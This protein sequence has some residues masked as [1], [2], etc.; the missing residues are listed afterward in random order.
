MPKIDRTDRFHKTADQ[1][2]TYIETKFQSALKSN[3]ITKDDYTLIRAFIEAKK[4]KNTEYMTLY[5]ILNFIVLWR[6]FMKVPY[7]KA[8]LNDFLSAKVDMENSTNKTGQPLYSKTYQKVMVVTVKGFFRWGLKESKIK[9]LNKWSKISE[10][11]IRDEIKPVKCKLKSKKADDIMKADEISRLIDAADNSRDRCMMSLQYECALRAVDLGRLRWSDITQISERESSIVVNSKTDYERH[12]STVL[13]NGYLNT[14]KRDATNASDKN[15]F[16]FLTYGT[17]QQITLDV[18]RDVVKNAAKRAGITDR[19]ATPHTLRHSR[20]TYWLQHDV[21]I[22][23]ICLMAWG[24]EY[25][26]MIKTYAHLGN[27]ETAKEQRR[28][29]GI[30]ESEIVQVGTIELKLCPVCGLNSPPGKGFCGGCGSPLTEAAINAREQAKN[31]AIN[32]KSITTAE[33]FVNALL[34][35]NI[36][37]DKLLALIEGL[38]K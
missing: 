30:K 36:S 15:G 21:S 10:A 19:Q 17:C 6:T 35:S 11:Q 32:S 26:P 38:K 13:F 37:E 4:G 33:K 24:V 16:V 2:E 31:D 28:L 25:S 12:I 29:A 7:R 27:D 23:K 8:I 14:W 1:W 22:A 9:T 3:T 18:V 34:S 20:I 5:H